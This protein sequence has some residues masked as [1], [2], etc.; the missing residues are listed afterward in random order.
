MKT[1]WETSHKWYDALVGEKGH[2]YHDHV[3]LP[4][5]L[6]LLALKPQDTLLD[7]GCGQGVLEKSLPK[8]V[9]YVGVDAS[10][11]LIQSARKTSKQP[12]YVADITA[13]L[14]LKETQFSHAA[15]ILV[16]QNLESFEGA[17]HNS[18]TYLKEGGKFL[19]VL[20]H[21]C[22]RIPRQSAW[23]IDDQKKLQYRRMDRYMESLKIPIQTHPGSPKDSPLTYSFHHP[24]STYTHALYTS[25]FVI[26]AL[27]EWVSDKKSVGGKSGMENR[28]RKEFPLFMAILA[29]KIKLA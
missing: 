7:L 8:Q 12:F 1:S 18:S 15:L 9:G 26:E 10:S 29:R 5:S 21:P 16:T 13:P 23:G 19:I 22:F 11:S 24:L 27:E 20:N 25:G 4:N 14:S 2:Y 3:V 17:F 28:A 6:R